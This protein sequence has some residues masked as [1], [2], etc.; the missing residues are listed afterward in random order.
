MDG[1]LSIDKRLKWWP[2][3]RLLKINFKQNGAEGWL[4]QKRKNME[5]VKNMEMAKTVFGMN[6]I[7]VE[8]A[9]FG[10]MTK[11]V[12]TPTNSPVVGVCLDFDPVNGEKVR[13][14][15]EVS[16]DKVESVV[17]KEGLPKACDNGNFRLS[18]CYSKDCQFAAL[19]LQQFSNFSY[20]QVGEIRF[21]EG[22]LAAKE[23]R[24]FVK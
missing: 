13:H 23:L 6:C 19:Q 15:I 9:L 8:K 18:I 20:H 17:E 24:P 22:E 11:V 4:R 21:A 16:P 1:F 5:N 12:Y 10:L 3:T 2:K 14:I 7:K